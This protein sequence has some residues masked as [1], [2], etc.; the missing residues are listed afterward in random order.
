MWIGVIIFVSVHGTL[1]IK[2]EIGNWKFGL[3]AF[4]LL[5]NAFNFEPGFST[6]VKS[7]RT[8]SDNASA[9]LCQRQACRQV[10]QIST[11]QFQVSSCERLL[12]FLSEVIIKKLEKFMIIISCRSC[13]MLFYLI[14]PYFKISIFFVFR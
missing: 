13:H 5:M 4:I 12:I 8:I 3:H 9:G 6:I 14:L 1:K 7:C 11:F 2:L 10:S